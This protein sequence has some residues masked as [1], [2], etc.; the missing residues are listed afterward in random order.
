[1]KKYVEEVIDINSIFENIPC[2]YILLNNQGI[3]T[4][5][6]KKFVEM[7]EYEYG[8]IINRN[9][10]EFL[11]VAS[12]MLFHSLFLVNI[13]VTGIVEE[14]YLTFKNKNGFHIPVLLN[15]SREE[16]ELINCV[17][18]RMNKRIEYEEE[19]QNI[20]KEL[21]VAYKEKNLALENARKKAEELEYLSYHDQLTGMYN[22]YFFD[23][24]I[25]EKMDKADNLNEPISMAILDIDHFKHVNDTWGHPVGD[26]VLKL[27]AKT[28][29]EAKD[30]SD[31]LVRLGGE[32][33]VVLMPYTE[34]KAATAKAEKIRLAIEENYHAVTGKQTVSIGVAE[35]LKYESF[36]NWY[37]RMDDSLYSA[38]QGGRNQVVSSDG[39]EKFHDM[40]ECLDLKKESLIGNKE[41]DTQHY[42]IN[43]IAKQLIWLI[44]ENKEHQ[45]IRQVLEL[46]IRQIKDHFEYEDKYLFDIK[47]PESSIH[48]DEH[49]SII[50]KLL[51]VK[52]DYERG[53]VKP[54]A[55]LSF[56][57]DEVMI[58]HLQ[59]EDIKYFIY[60]K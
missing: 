22:R 52:D 31:F 5:A 25:A 24:I 37:R 56:I 10:E 28:T 4:D 29:N 39:N 50:E 21:E 49:S 45:E 53:N 11:S 42:D 43:K 17:L 60:I 14:L 35:R 19:L 13:S 30:E 7:I 33:F 20:R 48:A 46:L 58:G 41:I 6:N 16:D 18:V 36:K 51:Q 57:V 9:I 1:M 34:I 15:G 12:K 2:S 23:T 44:Q 26:E 55:L 38:K 47:Y 59:N 27:T 3:I 8:D 54:V 32:E 40:G